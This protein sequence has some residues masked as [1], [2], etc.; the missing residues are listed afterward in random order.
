MP[1]SP[2]GLPKNL[3]FLNL[4]RIPWY[5]TSSNKLLPKPS[6][7]DRNR[8]WYSYCQFWQWSNKVQARLIQWADLCIYSSLLICIWPVSPNASSMPATGYVTPLTLVSICIV[9]WVLFFTLLLFLLSC[10]ATIIERWIKD[11]GHIPFPTI[12][13]GF[14]AFL[15]TAT[16]FC[17]SDESAKLIGLGKQHS[18]NLRYKKQWIY[19]FNSLLLSFI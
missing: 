10:Y 4:W 8:S 12:I 16:A 6:A 5:C 18:G 17:I 2:N 13:K 1:D 9:V 19:S 14:W 15:S 7:M 3:N 11:Y